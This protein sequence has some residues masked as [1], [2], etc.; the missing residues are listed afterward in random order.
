VRQCELLGISRSGYYYQPAD[1]DEENLWLMQLIDLQYLQTPFYGSRRMA[2]WLRGQG[3][4]VNRKRVQRLMHGMGIEAL[5]P[6][7]MLS[8][9][10]EGHMIYPYLL[11]DVEIVRPD[12]VWS[13]DITYIRMQRGF[14][15]LVAI[16]D[17]FSRYVLSWELSNTLDTQFCLVALERAL[18]SRRRPEIF[19]SDQ[20]SQF[21]ST[22]FTERLK[23][24]GVSISMDGCGRVYDNIFIERLWRTVKYEEVYLKDYEDP[25]AAHSNLGGYFHFYNRERPH[26]ALGYRTPLTVYGGN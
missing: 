1:E 16:L 19:N 10:R 9:P 11:R 14:L 26:Q 6:K 5:V 18:A 25:R 22:T 8:L 3:Y 4:A 15:Y 2:V 13:T 17:W 12:Q 20:G 7:R 23:Q 21:T 24:A